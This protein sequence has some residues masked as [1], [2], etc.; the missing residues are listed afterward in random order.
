LELRGVGCRVWS[1]RLHQAQRNCCESV[2]NTVGSPY[3]GAVDCLRVGFWNST[4]H[5][6]RPVHLIITMI[7]CIRTSRLSVKNSLCVE[8]RRQPVQRRRRLFQAC[9]LR[10]KEK[11]FFID[12]L[13]VRIHFI[14]VMI[15][16]T[17]LAPVHLRVQPYTLKPQPD[18]ERELRRQALRRPGARLYS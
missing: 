11:E 16:W 14:I 9:A 2:Q 6:A 15:R 10:L 13:L 4:T 5:G 3:S 18:G 8:H 12:N 17:G 1:Y 7:Q